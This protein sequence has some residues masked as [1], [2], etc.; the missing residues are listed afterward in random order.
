MVL[1]VRMRAYDHERLMGVFGAPTDAMPALEERASTLFPG[2]HA[3][4]WEGDP[5]TFQFSYVGRSAERVLGY[6]T[7]RWTSEPTF[8]ADHVVHPDDRNDAVAYCAL[9]TCK[10]ADHVFEY[11]AR[12]QDDS[13]IWLLDVV[14]VIVGERNLPVALRGVMLDISD[15][16]RQEGTFDQ[17]ASARHPA[18][19][20]L[21][22]RPDLR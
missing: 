21:A 17:A 4:V 18:R 1:S 7:H 13:I 19:D 6:P 2:E 14:R 3:I 22:E 12:R 15:A 20:A 16:K 11:R 9:A 8:W 5:A 10:G